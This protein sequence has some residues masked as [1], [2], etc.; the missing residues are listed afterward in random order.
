MRNAQTGSDA[1]SKPLR[2]WEI[3]FKIAVEAAAEAEARS[4]VD[5]VIDTMG[6][7]TAGSPQLV[8][9]DD[10]TWA[11]EVRIDKPAYE[12]AEPEDALSVLLTVKMNLDPLSWHGGAGTP[13]D[14]DSA[15]FAHIE[16]PP[17]YWSLGGRK[18][19]A[20]H[21]AV[22]ALLLQ[23]REITDRDTGGTAGTRE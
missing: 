4:I 18:E 13:L 17:S 21:P 5:L 11:T 3:V 14:P 10:G 2:H 12:D 8:P 23:A 1:V 9:F 19:T 6:G 22:R 16:W 7:T 15:R 20:V